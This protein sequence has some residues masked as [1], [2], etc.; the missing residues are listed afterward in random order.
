LNNSGTYALAGTN[1]SQV[2][3]GNPTLFRLTSSA[4]V[5]LN[6]GAAVIT[7]LISGG[8]L[9][10][11]PL[12]G[13]PNVSAIIT[14]YPDGRVVP[15]AQVHHGALNFFP[16]E[17]RPA[18][19]FE[20]I[21][22]LG[23]S[24]L[25]LPSAARLYLNG[26]LLGSFDLP[27]LAIPGSGDFFG[28]VSSAALALN[29]YSLSSASFTYR[30]QGGSFS[31]PQFSATLTVPRVNNG[32]GASASVGGGIDSAGNYTLTNSASVSSMSLAGL[33][34][35]VPTIDANATLRLGSSTG[36][37][38]GGNVSGGILANVPV[39]GSIT[40]LVTIPPSG[41][42]SIA[43]TVTLQKMIFG[44]FTI[45]STT[46]GNL[47][48]TWNSTGL[49]VSSSQLAAPNAFSSP[50]TLGAASILTSGSFS[51]SSAT[52]VSRSIR[53]YPCA[54]VS[55]TVNRTTGSISLNP[56]SA[57]LAFG[58]FNQTLNGSV[59][60]LGDGT[61]TV[62]L[63][64]DGALPLGGFNTSG[65]GYLDLRTAGLTA[66]GTFNLTAQSH[67]F[68]A[69]VSFS[70]SVFANGNYSLTGTGSLT[71][72]GG[73]ISSTS[74]TLTNSGVRGSSTINYGKFNAGGTAFTLN[75]GG[76]SFTGYDNDDSGWRW[77]GFAGVYWRAV[78][79][80]TLSNS[81][82]AGI[83]ASF[84]ADLY[85]WDENNQGCSV[86]QFPPCPKPANVSSVP[87]CQ[88]VD[89][90]PVTIN[91]N[92]EFSGGIGGCGPFDGFST[93]TLTLP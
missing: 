35:P 90:G 11:V 18:S 27:S 3:F 34:L 67:T 75:S 62:T 80:A 66:G 6:S 54:N 14:A 20:F 29:N 5:Q 60:G 9:N 30:K 74:L 22:I 17:I 83:S 31:I 68:N 51:P 81:G 82:A 28:S 16:F 25:A 87:S 77:T 61:V 24:G 23:Q 32:S 39:S 52:S 58:S 70:G 8:V 57:R 19:G 38:L 42:L 56:V 59:T 49:F 46:G 63:D 78:W 50:I 55:L 79:D 91:S 53:G 36:L 13:G 48:T 10:F 26:T 21:S 40:G 2:S 7:G 69:G 88:H 44:P 64:Y 89:I 4:S 76:V 86:G 92:G 12:N 71:L 85:G 72:S 33:G 73:N 37:T 65:N 15:Y 84:S 1:S 41:P 93:R 45:E 43:G 47:T